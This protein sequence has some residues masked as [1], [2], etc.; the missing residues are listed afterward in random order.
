MLT[1]KK[2]NLGYLVVGVV[3]VLLLSDYGRL[4]DSA[5][6]NEFNNNNND[7]DFN[8]TQSIDS[9]QPNIFR[10]AVNQSDLT[11]TRKTV[12]ATSSFQNNNNNIFKPNTKTVTENDYDHHLN[13]AAYDE[14][15]NDDDNDNTDA[16]LDEEANPIKKQPIQVKLYS[17]LN[18][19]SRNDMSNVPTVSPVSTTRINNY[20]LKATKST[21]LASEYD[22]GETGEEDYYQLSNRDSQP[23]H[24][25]HKSTG[26][27][28]LQKFTTNS[29]HS[30]ILASKS[31]Q[32]PIAIAT[33]IANSTSTYFYQTSSS[34][35]STTSTS[36]TSTLK[37][38]SSIT[39]AA[40]TTSKR[41]TTVTTSTNTS[42]DS[43]E[44]NDID[45]EN[46]NIINDNDDDNDDE[47]IEDDDYEKDENHSLPVSTST[48]TTTFTQRKSIENS[49]RTTLASTKKNSLTTSENTSK[50]IDY[51]DDETE[52]TDDNTPAEDEE[53]DNQDLLTDEDYQDKLHST[54]TKNNRTN[55]IELKPVSKLASQN[56]TSISIKA[57]QNPVGSSSLTTK[58][59]EHKNNKKENEYAD[60]EDEYAD[61]EDEEDDDDYANDYDSDKKTKLN[62]DS[63]KNKT[64]SI[65]KNEDNDVDYEG[66][67]LNADEDEYNEEVNADTGNKKPHEE[68]L[69]EEEDGEDDDEYDED[70]KPES[71]T[72]TPVTDVPPDSSNNKNLPESEDNQDDDEDYIEDNEEDQ[73]KSLKNQINSSVQLEPDTDSSTA[74]SIS[75]NSTPSLSDVHLEKSTETISTSTPFSSTNTVFSSTNVI[76]KTSSETELVTTTTILAKDIPQEA[77]KSNTSN[78]EEEI[79]DQTNLNEFEGETEDDDDDDDDDEDEIEID[80]LNEYNDG[81][82]KNDLGKLKFLFFSFLFHSKKIQGFNNIHI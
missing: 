40:T 64:S 57:I 35:S 17:S 10:P 4:V 39:T 42:T 76:S 50:D 69:A 28:R 55:T 70:I 32:I 8:V 56:S 19:T 77:N 11:S 33:S 7:G 58:N 61:E 52:A 47:N 53:E 46:E 3:V 31:T 20:M 21:P 79:S 82:F 75:I 30:D 27:A 80:P 38:P 24:S 22:I 14:D 48:S 37:S 74:I 51:Y 34:T 72:T 62:A 68:N 9:N 12:L 65:S 71:E 5:P 60:Q 41:F 45:N 26:V 44:Y 16:S 23:L 81:S 6:V 36:T 25:V 66:D 29:I 18:K 78:N 63:K 54:N 2:V 15:S 1:V 13:E 49:K 67:L 73:D 59:N 43:Y